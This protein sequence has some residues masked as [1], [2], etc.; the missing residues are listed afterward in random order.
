MSWGSKLA[1]A[2]AHPY[3]LLPYTPLSPYFL[4][5]TWIKKEEKR[6]DKERGR[7][8]EIGS[9][10]TGIVKVLPFLPPRA[11]VEQDWTPSTVMLGHLQK[12]MRHGFMLAAELETYWV[13]K[14]PALLAPTEGYVVSFMAFHERGFG[15]PP[16]P[17]LHSLVRYYGLELH[18][19]APSGVLHIAVFVTL[20]EV[21]L[22]CASSARS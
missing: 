21:F 2:L 3:V 17:F 9:R 10:N 12:F 7:E 6:R 14:D 15:V 19:L 4:P 18:H 11:M 22:P 20:C 5:C 16:H 13:L 8:K 1:V